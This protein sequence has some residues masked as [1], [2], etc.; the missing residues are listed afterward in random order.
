MASHCEPRAP[1][2]GH[3]VRVTVRRE[4]AKSAALSLAAITAVS[5]GGFW[6]ARTAATQEAVRQAQA[7]TELLATAIISPAVDDGLLTG[8]S[9]SIDL[10]DEAV[11]THVL[12][13]RILT[14]RVWSPEGVILYSDDLANVG[15]V[16]PLGSEERDVLAT[17]EAHADLSDLAKLENADQ[18]DFDQLLEVYVPVETPSGQR[19]LFETYQS[20]VDLDSATTRILGAF[21][22]V[23]LGVLLVFGLIQLA[24]SWRLARTLERAQ[25]ERED[26][27]QRALAASEA[28]RR[29]IAADLHDGV[30][31]DL[32][33]LTFTLDGMAG[34]ASDPSAQALTDAAG[35]SRR[36]V[37]SL[38]SLL[39]EIYPPNLEDIGMAGAL[40]DLAT[41]I[42]SDT[43]RVHV[44]VD[45]D[46]H[47]EP[48]AQAAVYRVARESLSNARKHAR[49][50]EVDVRL[51]REAHATV[52]TVSDNGAGFDARNVPTGHMGLRMMRDV[53]ASVGATLTVDSAPGRGTTLRME[54]P[55]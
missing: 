6:A 22:P 40:A 8:D 3:N 24:L 23:M 54:L 32:V 12:G 11:Q 45:P 53:A 34:G 5:V 27:L 4:V 15:Q 31:Q 20:T 55:A 16:F 19:L 17:G 41:A 37:R 36:S 14:V 48:A 30:V 26:L 10:L 44:R 25:A 18:A 38:R 2:T 52:L 46:A 1:E 42:G 29:S 28:E 33:G 49:A 39:V 7:A 21:A 13:E 43:L 35:T 51:T 47:L 50:A 9:D